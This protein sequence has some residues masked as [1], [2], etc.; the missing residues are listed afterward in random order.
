MSVIIVYD[1]AD[2]TVAGRV[3]N[4]YHSAHTPDYDGVSDKLVNPDLSALSVAQK[5][6]K[7]SAGSIIEMSQAEKDD[8]DGGLEAA[9]GIKIKAIDAR[10]EE[11]IA[12]GFTY[13]SKVFSLSIP[14]QS[15]MTAAHQIKDDVAFIY[16]VVWNTISDDSTYSIADATDMGGFYMTA[17]GTIRARLDS[18]TALKDSARAAADIAAVDAVV[19]TR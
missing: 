15:K 12:L 1:P 14:S 16:P 8:I 7:H 19:D 4:C 2:V 5:Y 18:G 6:W 9:R 11:L 13:A 10:T 17:I 3:T